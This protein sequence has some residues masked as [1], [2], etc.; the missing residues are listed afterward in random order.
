MKTLSYCAILSDN[1][2]D[3]F[4]PVWT[5]CKCLLIGSFSDGSERRTHCLFIVSKIYCAALLQPAVGWLTLWGHYSFDKWAFQWKLLWT[6]HDYLSF[7]FLLAVMTSIQVADLHADSWLQHMI[8]AS[9]QDGPGS[10]EDVTYAVITEFLLQYKDPVEHCVLYPQLSLRWKPDD[11]KDTRTEIPDIGVGNFSLQAPGPCFKMRL[12][13]ESKR[14]V[15]AMQN[16]PEPMAIQDHE[17]VLSAFHTVFYQ[18]EDQAKAAIKGGHTL[19]E[20]IP[21]L[22][23]IGPYFTPV[24]FGLFNLQQLGVR[25]HKPSGSIS[26]WNCWNLF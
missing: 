18:A 6:Q 10:R 12:G 15:G 19:S 5:Q 4:K 13:V 7:V 24:K 9:F 21:Y 20:T 2:R 17:D 22:L 3:G 26:W 23:F 8:H 16:L 25:T 11:P 1:S 14:L